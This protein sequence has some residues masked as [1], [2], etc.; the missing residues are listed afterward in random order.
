MAKPK[1]EPIQTAPEHAR[2]FVAGW[3]GPSNKTQ[4]YWWYH[5]DIIIDGKPFEYIGATHWFPLALP[6]FPMGEASNG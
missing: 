2:V 5:E 4:G 3:Q 6:D 1:L